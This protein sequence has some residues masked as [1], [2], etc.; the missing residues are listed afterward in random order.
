MFTRMIHEIQS[1]Y[2]I[3]VILQQNMGKIKFLEIKDKEKI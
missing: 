1:W 2:E 3:L